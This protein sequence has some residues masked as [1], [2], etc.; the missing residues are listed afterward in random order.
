MEDGGGAAE[1]PAGWTVTT[2]GGDPGPVAGPCFR[3]VR[4]LARKAERIYRTI[5]A[6]KDKM[7]KWLGGFDTLEAL[8]FHTERL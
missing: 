4:A 5:G 7:Q 1:C 6:H 2:R 8:A 3:A